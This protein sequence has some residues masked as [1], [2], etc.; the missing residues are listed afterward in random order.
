MDDPASGETKAE[1]AEMVF[2]ACRQALR[3]DDAVGRPFTQ[4]SVKTESIKSC[5]RRRSLF[6]HP[7]AAKKRY[8]RRY[9]SFRNTA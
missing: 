1:R 8:T 9:R 5:W 2:R 3:P 6:G 4:R 7:N